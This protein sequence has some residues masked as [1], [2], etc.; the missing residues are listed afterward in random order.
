MRH[1]RHIGGRAAHN[2][3][4]QRRR[5]LQRSSWAQACRRAR[6]HREAA[7]PHD[8]L[9]ITPPPLLLLLARVTEYAFKA[10]RQ[11][12]VTSIGVRGTD[13][14][15]FITQK[16]VSVAAGPLSLKRQQPLLCYQQD[17][18]LSAGVHT[19]THARPRPLLWRP[20]CKTS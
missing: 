9:L 6:A 4:E 17:R 14:V 13:C 3:P 12:G 2:A 11:S 15:V 16:K 20:R 19:H 5:R 1:A 10:V 8:S 18:L 7:L